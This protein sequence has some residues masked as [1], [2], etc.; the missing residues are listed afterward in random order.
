MSI[1]YKLVSQAYLAGDRVNK[2]SHQFSTEIPFQSYQAFSSFS[3][4]FFSFGLLEY[5]SMVRRQRNGNDTTA[6]LF[7]YFKNIKI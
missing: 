3:F 2:N 4:L 6:C 7:L 5:Y 1:P